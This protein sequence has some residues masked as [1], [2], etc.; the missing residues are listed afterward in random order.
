MFDLH[1]KS[2]LITGGTG[3]LGEALVKYMLQQNLPVK[4]IVIFSRDEY[5]QYEMRRRF[6]QSHYPQLQFVIGDI[7][8]PRHVDKICKGI[9]V[10][11]HAAA[12]KQ[13]LAGEDNPTAFVHTNILGTENLMSAALLSAVPYFIGLSTDKA[14]KP[15]SLYGATKLCAEKIIVASNRTTETTRCYVV[16]LGNLLGS[17]GSVIPLFLEK[18]GS[19]SFPITHEEMTRFSITPE[20]SVSFVLDSLQWASG[21][22]IFVP[23]MSSYHVKDLAKAIDP[24]AQWQ[25]T[26]LRTGEKIHETLISHEESIR[27]IDMGHYYAVLPSDALKKNYTALGGKPVPGHFSYT[28]SNNESFLSQ[29]DLKHLIKD[30]L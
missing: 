1:N 15:T 20:A 21:T 7:C 30:S 2:F 17:R 19:G 18:K 5:K 25:T 28:S 23:K 9:D 14:V 3:T 29:E 13:L 4:Q 27:T 26:G 11:I 8:N 6:P 16:R 10:I 12:L 22:E 24:T